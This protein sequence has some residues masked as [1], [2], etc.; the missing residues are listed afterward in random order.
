VLDGTASLDAYAINRERRQLHA[1]VHGIG[2]ERSL[3][4]S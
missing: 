1:W 3:P 2:S 4:N